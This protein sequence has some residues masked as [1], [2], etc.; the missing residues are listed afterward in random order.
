MELM[1]NGWINM[2]DYVF[3]RY[4]H[5]LSKISQRGTKQ[6]YRFVL[7][8]DFTDESD[9][10]LAKSIDLVGEEFF[11]KYNFSDDEREHIKNSIKDI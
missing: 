4:L 5:S 6:K 1:A 10:N 8:Q 9:I 2:Y 11:E 3:A 7:V